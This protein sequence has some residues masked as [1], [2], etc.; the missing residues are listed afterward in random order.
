MNVIPLRG[1]HTY[2]NITF[3]GFPTHFFLLYAHFH[4]HPGNI[5]SRQFY[6]FRNCG[7]TIGL[8]TRCI[9]YEYET[10]ARVMFLSA[11]SNHLLCAD[12]IFNNLKP[13]FHSTRF[14]RPIY[15]TAIFTIVAIAV[16]ITE[17]NWFRFYDTRDAR[18]PFSLYYCKR[19]YATSD[20]RAQHTVHQRRC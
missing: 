11:L 4:S 10:F 6:F 18:P 7:E 20:C 14:V 8:P 17:I 9:V 5:Y 15:R 12:N 16:L 2:H 13:W 19:S 1:T 3:F